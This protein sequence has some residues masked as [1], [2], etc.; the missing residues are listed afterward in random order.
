MKVSVIIPTYNRM[1]SLRQL[2]ATLSQQ[3]YPPSDFEVIVVD[4]GSTDATPDVV[5]GEFICRLRYYRQSNSGAPAARNLGAKHSEGDLLIFLDDDISVQPRF[6]ASLV[7]EHA[8]H[9]HII[10]LGTFRPYVVGHS[11]PFGAIYA[12]ITATQDVRP[13]DNG[14][15]PFVELTSNCFSVQRTAFCAIGM[16][17]DPTNGKLWPNW[18]DLDFAYRAHLQGFRFRRSPLAVCFHRDHAV[19]DLGTYC[20]RMERAARAAVCL[21]QKYPDLEAELPMFRDKGPI[22]LK[23]DSVS[24]VVRKALR[25][26]LS[27]GP[28]MWSM[29]RVV[30]R[31][32]VAFPKPSLLVPLYRWMVGGYLYRGYRQGLC[33][34]SAAQTEM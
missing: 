6:I 30:R 17:Q 27:S 4:D 7:Q 26:V 5:G 24:L 13:E 2:L 12:Q 23:Q 15:V 10:G 14:F 1:D 29:E 22:S 18:D 9:D 33:R 3:T 8:T 28:A 11:T 20:R 34:Y 32:E 19:R 16:M 31:V 25:S 21:F